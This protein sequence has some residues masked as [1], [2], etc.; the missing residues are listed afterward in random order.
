MKSATD[1][2]L[3]GNGFELSVPR[4]RLLEFCTALPARTVHP[5][6]R[7]CAGRRL[8]KIPAYR[9]GETRHPRVSGA[10][11][12]PH[13]RRAQHEPVSALYEQGRIHHTSAPS[14]KLEDQM[15]AFT[16]D[17]DRAL[18]A[19]PPRCAGVG[20]DRAPGRADAALG[21]IRVHAPARRGH[22]R[23]EPV[24]A[25]ARVCDRQ[26]GVATP[27]RAGQGRPMVT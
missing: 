15:C 1:S 24:T 10:S 19:G 16:T 7:L 25:G 9:M 6:S 21:H 23:P 11:C 26:P 12:R 13:R 17:L 4:C 18:L 22:S 2:S 8:R 14:P 20:V 5:G 27:A 3:E